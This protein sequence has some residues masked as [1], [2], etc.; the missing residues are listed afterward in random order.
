[1]DE[2]EYKWAVRNH[3][4][5]TAVSP[6]SSN[7]GAYPAHGVPLSGTM[8]LRT[9]YAKETDI[10][11][12]LSGTGTAKIPGGAAAHGG[13]AYCWDMDWSWGSEVVPL[14]YPG[15][16]VEIIPLGKGQYCV[17]LTPAPEPLFYLPE[18]PVTYSKS[19]CPLAVKNIRKAE[20]LF[21]AVQNLFGE[22]SENDFDVARP[23][24]LIDKAAELLKKAKMFSK[25]N[26]NCIAA[27]TLAIEAQKLL[28][29]AKEILESMM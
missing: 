2:D 14:Q 16:N 15:F 22:A 25:N 5:A 27:N 7:P 3:P 21:E 28:Q 8:E 11:V 29:K 17:I 6:W 24:E 4:G 12:Y 23:K 18:Q 9:M 26:Q 1:M 19:L 13:G 20:N 10:G